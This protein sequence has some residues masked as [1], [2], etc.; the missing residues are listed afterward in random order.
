M[1]CRP[2]PHRAGLVET[3][4]GQYALPALHGLLIWWFSTCLILFLDG[5]PQTD[6]PLEHGRRHGRAGGARSTA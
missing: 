1:N 6:L 4:H 3:A 5:L 2:S